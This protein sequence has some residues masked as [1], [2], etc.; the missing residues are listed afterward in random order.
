MFQ[1][2][3][4]RP[5]A[6]LAVTRNLWFHSGDLGVFDEEGFLYFKDRKKDYLRRRG[7]NIS[8]YEV[9]TTFFEHPAVKEVAVHAVPSTMTEDE[10]KVTVVLQP[11]CTI[12]ERELCEWSVDRLPYFAVPRFVEF[13]D[14]LPKNPVGRVMK[15]QLRDEGVTP[16]TFDRESSDVEIR[17]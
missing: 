17:R 8:S 3:W 13:R 15:Y 9:E 6:T 16:T 1:G 5:E 11:G 12:T 2:Y 10:V 4:N 14:E 7:E